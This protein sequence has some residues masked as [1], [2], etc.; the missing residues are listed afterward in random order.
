MRIRQAQDVLTVSD[1]EQLDAAHSD[2]FQSAVVAALAPAVKQIDIDLSSTG[3]IDC[4]GVGALVALRK[5][6]RR[7]NANA[8]LRLRNAGQLVRRLLRLTHADEMFTVVTK[9]YQAPK[10]ERGSSSA[11]TKEL[12]GDHDAAGFYRQNVSR[13]LHETDRGGHFCLFFFTLV[14]ILAV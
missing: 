4:G 11:A 14:F 9:G 8:T 7:C 5:R 6:A 2:S 12:R 3:V 13:L 10:P 1:I